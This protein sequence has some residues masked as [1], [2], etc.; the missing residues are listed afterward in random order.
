[1]T[2]QK[3]LLFSLI[4][5]VI[6]IGSWYYKAFN[7]V[8]SLPAYENDL[9]NEQ[10]QLIKI[11]DLKGRY[12]LISYFQTWCGTCIQELPSIDVLQMKVGKDKLEV[13][14][15]SDE[16]FEKI[17]SF[18]EKYCNTLNYYKSNKTL[19]KQSIRIFPTTYLL[20]KEGVV[21]MSKL[22]AYDWSSDEVVSICVN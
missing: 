13:L 14:M 16:S 21:I 5:I 11:A 18:K 17:N 4:A 20:N 10:G 15:V 3:V 22:N 6:A 19:Q 9:T 2:T 12:V 8:P 1:M 7:T